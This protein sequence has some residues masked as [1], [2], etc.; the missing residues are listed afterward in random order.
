M[1]R[2]KPAFGVTRKVAV[3]SFSEINFYVKSMGNRELPKMI[4]N[5]KNAVS[6]SNFHDDFVG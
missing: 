6:T 2:V 3:L 4:A 1:F 5:I